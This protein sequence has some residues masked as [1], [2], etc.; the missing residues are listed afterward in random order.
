MLSSHIISCWKWEDSLS[1]AAKWAYKI[2][3]TFA[4]NFFDRPDCRKLEVEEPGEDSPESLL[5][6][7]PFALASAE[8]LRSCQSTNFRSLPCQRTC[9]SELNWL[10]IFRQWEY[11]FDSP[12][13]HPA[14][15]TKLQLFLSFRLLQCQVVAESKKTQAAA[16]Q[17]KCSMRSLPPGSGVFCWCIFFLLRFSLQIVFVALREQILSNWSILKSCCKWIFLLF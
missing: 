9:W 16:L 11:R 4:W 14:H 1:P 7:T 5:H 10:V 12:S 3:E 2:S 13:N 6:W 17:I 15:S 8:D